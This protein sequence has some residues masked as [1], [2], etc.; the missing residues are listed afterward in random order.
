MNEH[1]ASIQST[2]FPPGTKAYAYIRFSSAQQEE[3][4]SLRRQVSKSETYAAK[5]GLTVHQPEHYQDRGKSGFTGKN[6]SGGKLGEFLQACE[7]GRIEKG[8]VLL[9]ESF[10][11]LSRLPIMEANELFMR[12]IRLGVTIVTLHDDQVFSPENMSSPDAG[13]KMI[14]SLVGMMRAHEESDRKSD[15]V[16]AAWKAKRA[17]MHEVKQ[18]A[19]CPQWMKLS[20]DR[21]TFELIDSSVQTV[22]RIIDLQMQG[23]GQSLIVKQLN[24]EGVPALSYRIKKKPSTGWHLST[25]QRL[26]TSP[27]LYGEYQRVEPVPERDPLTGNESYPLRPVGDPIP[28]YYP[29]IISRDEFHALQAVRSERAKK[30]RGRKGQGFANLFSGLLRC[31]Y[32][33]ASMTIGAHSH[34][35]KPT[36]RYIVCS[37]AKRGMGCHF[38]MWNYDNFEHTVMSYLQGID[39]AGLVDDKR[40]TARL[41]QQAQGKV[42]AIQQAQKDNASS[43]EKAFKLLDMDGDLSIVHE[44]LKQLQAEKHQLAT[45]E[46]EALSDVTSIEQRLTDPGDTQAS[47]IELYKVLEKLSANEAALPE[48]LAKRA[49]I[50]AQIRRVVRRINVYPGGTHLLPEFEDDT[51]RP[52]LEDT[53]SLLRDKIAELRK[54]RDPAVNWRSMEGEILQRIRENEA[55]LS[56]RSRLLDPHTAANADGIELGQS[57]D[58]RPEPDRTFRTARIIGLNGCEYSTPPLIDALLCGKEAQAEIMHALGEDVEAQLGARYRVEPAHGG[59]RSKAKRSMVVTP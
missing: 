37:G 34:K 59:V 20:A 19:T 11:R 38:L 44:R 53:T 49:A 54:R 13:F 45:R 33:G 8:S 50:A 36:K 4:D 51:K 22:K 30:G 55:T 58:A 57:I 16:G 5:H 17:K 31:G 26:L 41:L 15:R 40:S 43:I 6:V 25:I 7:E 1:K 39:F 27:A 29:A 9:I 21:K 10:D 3:G 14:I 18:T 35:D 56:K 52:S 46:A 2:P 42:A 32:C 24:A 47:V 23:V 48:L 28:D 12:I